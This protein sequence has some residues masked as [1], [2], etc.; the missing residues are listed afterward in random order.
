MLL[1]SLSHFLFS[2]KCIEQPASIMLYIFTFNGRSAHYTS[3][4]LGLFLLDN[5]LYS[6]APARMYILLC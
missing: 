3:H 6:I 4:T 2:L 1:L 5:L